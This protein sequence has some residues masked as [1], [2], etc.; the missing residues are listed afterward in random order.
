[1]TGRAA[2][3]GLGAAAMGAA[4]ASSAVP[5]PIISAASRRIAPMRPTKNSPALWIA[6][7]AR[8]VEIMD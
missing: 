5:S 3:A 7:E 6:L 1:M 2:D 8:F 4:E